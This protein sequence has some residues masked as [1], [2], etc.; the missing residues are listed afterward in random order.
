MLTREDMIIVAMQILIHMS[1]FLVQF[2]VPFKVE[3]LKDL[4]DNSS[5][6]PDRRACVAD[7]AAIELMDLAVIY[8][9]I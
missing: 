8:S 6:E 9:W 2:L 3:L 4:V 7:L 5:L 1:S